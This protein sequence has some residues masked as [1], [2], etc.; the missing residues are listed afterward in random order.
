LIFWLAA[1][2]LAI[3]LGGLVFAF[4][5]LAA[6]RA[7]KQ[8]EDPSMAVY[9]RQ[10]EEL[11]E[12]AGRGLLPE[13]EQR[14]ARAEAGRRLISAADRKA[15]TETAG[16]RISK[17]AV[18]GGAVAAAAGAFAMYLWLGSPGQGD[19]PYRAR[20]KS[21]AADLEFLPP[22]ELAA[23]LRQ[24]VA[25]RPQDV[26]GLI[27]LGRVEAAAG[28]AAAA[29]R[30][31]GRARRLEPNNIQYVAL[32]AEA[33][34]A[35]SEG[36]VTPEAEAALR[37]LIALDPTDAMARFYLAK[38]DITAGRT[39]QGLAVWKQLEAQL[40]ADDPSKARIRQEIANVE[41]TGPA[42][43][44]A[45]AAQIAQADAPAQAQFIK[46]MVSKLAGRLKEKP[47]DPDGWAR[48]IRAYGVLND[49]EAQARAIADMKKVYAARPGM[50][51]EIENSAKGRPQ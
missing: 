2:A 39:Q 26:Q 36:T 20:L 15:Q 4:S 27:Y 45:L 35:A 22:Q 7:E 3:G 16:G 25:K 30:A 49:K 43:N 11:D 23:V 13:A 1:A 18:A 9:R 34:L 31:Y 8:V 6:R 21:W 32:E 48:L 33:Q 41:G 51:L 42:A 44:P 37:R 10:L 29:A 19:Q 28:D 5:G 17:L 38:A 47:D 12:L 24:A 50:A 14:A 46:G 40:P